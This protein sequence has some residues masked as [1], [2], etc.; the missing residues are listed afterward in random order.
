MSPTV[1]LRN[2]LPWPL[3]PRESTEPEL[4]EKM[5]PKNVRLTPPLPLPL[6]ADDGDKGDAGDEG[7]ERCGVRGALVCGVWVYI[8]AELGTCDEGVQSVNLLEGCRRREGRKRSAYVRE[9]SPFLISV[10]EIAQN[11]STGRGDR[12]R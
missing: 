2:R 10:V 9:T 5:R 1:C 8:E 11:E 4:R 6:P 7:P 3:E 12:P